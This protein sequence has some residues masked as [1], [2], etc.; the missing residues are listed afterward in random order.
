MRHHQTPR[1]RRYL[2]A[3][4]LRVLVP[5]HGYGN[6]NL[7]RNPGGACPPAQPAPPPAD[8]AAGRALGRA[9]GSAS[10]PKA[11][12]G[13]APARRLAA[14]APKQPRS[15]A[16]ARFRGCPARHPENCRTGAEAPPPDV[17]V[18]SPVLARSRNRSATVV[19]LLVCG[20]C[21]AGTPD[22][23]GAAFCKSVTFR[24]V[25]PPSPAG[26]TLALPGAPATSM[27]QSSPRASSGK[28]SP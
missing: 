2:D 26:I 16:R 10:G 22:A 21:I 18:L 4:R 23:A 27:C 11:R 9:A 19:S 5:A 6:R 7:R 3:L 1:N 15:A 24:G 25:A 12:S 20:I 13:P 14:P 17:P 8:F 28:A